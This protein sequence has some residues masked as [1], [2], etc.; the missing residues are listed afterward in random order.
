MALIRL[1]KRMF[2]TVSGLALTL[3]LGTTA[4]LADWRDD[5]PGARSV[6]TGQFK[7]FGIAVYE[8]RLWSRDSSPTLDQP[9]A[10]ELT[11]RREIKRDALVETSLDEIRRLGG[12]SLDQKRLSRW[13]YEMREAF[14]DVAPGQSITGLYLPGRGCRFYVDGQLSREVE[15]PD[16]ARA[17]FA[18]WLDPRTR[19][20]ELR[21]RLLGLEVAAE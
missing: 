1:P 9:F 13:A 3:W 14:V 11:Y 19:N 21:R 4:A 20:P 15:D 8:A 2:P 16:F 5:L 12:E 6:G 17:F 7:W 18:I 10:L